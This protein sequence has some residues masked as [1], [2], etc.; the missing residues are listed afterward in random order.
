MRGVSDGHKKGRGEG[1]GW[2]SGWGGAAPSGATASDGGSLA[3]W[4]FQQKHKEKRS[5]VSVVRV[6]RSWNKRVM[7]QWPVW[8]GICL[9]L[10][11]G[12]DAQEDGLAKAVDQLRQEMADMR[13]QRAQDQRTMATLIR[14]CQ[15][16]RPAGIDSPGVEQTPQALQSE[17]RPLSTLDAQ[18]RDLK[19]SLESLAVHKNW[20]SRAVQA[21]RNELLLVK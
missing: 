7:E 2:I 10:T 9:L 11:F 8:T 3:S 19:S 15:G 12:I 17:S 16:G 1:G 21:F 6:P 20:E 14:R 5:T 13:Q 4:F 18:I